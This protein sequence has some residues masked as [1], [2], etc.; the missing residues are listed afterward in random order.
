MK[1]EVVKAV[2]SSL[3]EAGVN[4]ITSLPST[5][6]WQI[7]LA[8]KDDPYFTHVPV[9]N[10]EDAIGICAGAWAGG[11]KPALVAQNCGLVMATYA[12]TGSCHFFGGF[13][14]LMVSDQRGDFGDQAGYWYFGW[15]DMT[16]KI[17]DNLGL[18]YVVVKDSDKFAAEVL[19]GQRT[20]EACGKPVAVLL[21]GEEIY[22]K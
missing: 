15:A 9:N 2:V 6:V 14:M 19:Y 18:L 1:V 22:G 4:F 8:I 3:K 5:G 7:I 16:I 10:E 20:A 21:S 11:K 12:L 17:L 13:P